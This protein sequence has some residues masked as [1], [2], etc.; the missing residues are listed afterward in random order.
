MGE[1]DP[2][3]HVVETGLDPEVTKAVV[4]GTAAKLFGMGG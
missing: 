2:I 3:G 4:G 1:Y